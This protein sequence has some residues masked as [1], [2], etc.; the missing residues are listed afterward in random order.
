M[1]LMGYGVDARLVMDP[2]RPTGTRLVVITH[3]GEHTVLSDPGAN[4]TLSTDDLPLDLFTLGNHMHVSGY[5]L[6]SEGARPAA[7]AAIQFSIRAGMTVS[8]DAA[9]PAPL[10]RIGAEPF[11]ELTDGATLLFV[12]QAEGHVL[13]GREDP[14]QMARVLTAWY[15]QVVAKMGADGALF[16]AQGG[17]PVHVPAAPM[18]RIIDGTGAGDAFC[19]GFLRP[20]LDKKPPGEALANGCRLAAHAMSLT[21][22]RPVL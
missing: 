19:A 20:W 15:P 5:T 2:E 11:L 17:P 10:E 4:A 1:E 7:L 18:D 9:S 16:Y 21:G 13:T 8:V 12:N 3:K 22:A 14:E 6:L